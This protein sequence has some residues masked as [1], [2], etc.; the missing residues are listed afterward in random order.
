MGV[1]TNMTN[2]AYRMLETFG[3]DQSIT[4]EEFN[5]YKYDLAYSTHSLVAARV[6]ELIALDAM[7]DA[8]MTAAQ[9]VLAAWDLR[10]NIDSRQAALAVLTIAPIE[11]A[12][13]DGETSPDLREAFKRTIASLKAHFGR[14]DPRW[15]EV[16]RLRRGGLDI[17]VDGGPDI[18][19]AVYGTPQ[20]DGTLTGVA[21][22]TLIMFV[23][24]D[25]MGNLSSRS[26][27]QFGE[28]TLDANSPHYADQAPLFASMKTKPVLFTRA[29]L[30]GHV[31]RD[32]RPGRA[33][34]LRP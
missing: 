15:G 2:R 18:L 12:I 33:S 34:P 23:E 21:G 25:R 10:T 19:R 7:G 31:K 16:N 24:W 17:A 8:D 28:A 14:I 11:R 26:I 4:A 29:E 27:H 20:A 1:Q 30:E 13:D 32:Y 6:R 3:A 5:A 22:D 9:Q